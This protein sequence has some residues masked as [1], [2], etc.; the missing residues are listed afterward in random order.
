[1]IEALII[2]GIYLIGFVISLTIWIF[3]G[4]KIDKMDYDS[5][6]P[7]DRWPD[8]WESNNDFYIGMSTFWFLTMPMWMVAGIVILIYRISKWYLD[9]KL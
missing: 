9:F 5:I 2:I 8:D 6:K 4:K 3:F 7:E 1:M